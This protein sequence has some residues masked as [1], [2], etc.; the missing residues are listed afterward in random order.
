MPAR[1][2]DDDQERI[3]QRQA[4]FTTRSDDERMCL[5]LTIEA[6]AADFLLTIAAHMRRNPADILDNL[7]ACA[8]ADPE[9]M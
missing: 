4:L 6:L 7:T 8:M 5:M 3:A 1:L 9:E 2:I